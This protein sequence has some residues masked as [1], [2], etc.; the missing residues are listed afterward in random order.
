LGA[1]VAGIDAGRSYT[2]WP[3]MGGQFLPPDPFMIEPVWRNFLENPGLVQF[4]HRMTGYLLFLFS[5]M[6]FF[7]ARR[8]SNRVTA[9][10][11]TVAFVALT[12][13]VAL[14]IYTV[15]SAAQLHVALT[16]QLL[17]VAT[18]VLILRARFHAA[19]P[20]PQSV[21]DAR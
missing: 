6:V 7:R 17:A 11:Y 8:A 15:I 20:L 10:A 4:I 1:L 18:F 5:V 9:G 2:D 16:H 3:T 14:G 12:G 13:Q 21:R 19:Y